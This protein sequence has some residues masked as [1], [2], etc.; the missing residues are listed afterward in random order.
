MKIHRIDSKGFYGTGEIETWTVTFDRSGEPTGAIIIG[1]LGAHD[2]P[3]ATRFIANAEDDRDLLQS[4]TEADLVG[5]SG[6]VTVNEAQGRN[7]FRAG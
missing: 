4:M 2:D 7:Q 1:R 3:Q 5:V 6:T